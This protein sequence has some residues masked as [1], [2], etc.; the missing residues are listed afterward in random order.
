[1]S[2]DVVISVEN[3]S[4]RYRLGEI[5]ATSIREAAERWWH[6]IKTKESHHGEHG[7]PSTSAEHP[8]SRR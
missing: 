1:M 3:L 4:K 7:G 5:G 6:R 8:G 2:S